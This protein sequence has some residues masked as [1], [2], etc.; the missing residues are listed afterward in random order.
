MSKLGRIWPFVGLT[1]LIAALA[2]TPL[3]A[4]TRASPW[5]ITAPSTQRTLALGAYIPGAPS[6]PTRIDRYAAAVGSMPRVVMW[7]QGWAGEWNEF[8]ARGANAIR[9]RGAMPMITWEPWAGSLRDARWSLARIANGA[10][11]AYLRSW[12]RDVARWSHPI[13]VRPMHEMNGNWTSW[14]PGVNGNTAADFRAAWR[15]IVDIG[16][17]QGAHNIRWV[18]CPNTAYPGSTPFEAVWPGARY[19][20]WM[21]LDGYNWGES[22]ASG[23]TW[24]RGLLQ[25]SVRALAEISSKPIMIGETAS[26]EKGGDKALWILRGFRRIADDMPQV[27]AVVWF[28]KAQDGAD[29]PV[30]TS[31]RS[32]Q[33]FRTMASWDAYSGRLP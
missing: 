28:N 21:C 17:A 4:A 2:A 3:Q 30:D 7:Y 23:W 14:S 13:Y 25:P 9:A 19:V 24:M 31:R 11:D 22:R 20:D 18:W 1:L 6:D 26:S 33:A 15:H 8:Y 29:W 27:K 10:H 16:N 32:L 5:T 12:L